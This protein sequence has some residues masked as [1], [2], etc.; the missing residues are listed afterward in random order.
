MLFSNLVQTNLRTKFLGQQIEYY[1]RLKST[2]EEGW[3]LS[4]D[5][6]KSG[7]V[8][9]TDNQFG[10]KGRNSRNWFTTP[11][12]SLSFSIL[13]EKEI[14]VKLC[15]WIPIITALSIERALSNFKIQIL[16][17]WPN[18]IILN[19]EK[20]GGVLIESKIKG[21]LV[22]KLIIGIGLNINE[23]KEE[24]DPTIK[25]LATSL[26]IYSGKNFQRER[27]LAEILNEMEPIIEGFPENIDMIRKSWTANCNHIDNKVQFHRGSNIISGIFKGLGENGSA[28]LKTNQSEKEFHSGEVY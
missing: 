13:I 21:K 24:L 27:I 20:I 28:I 2:N 10:G 25:S 6:A 23:S 9:I 7:T 26:H 3:E 18:D 15:G 5:G 8:V 22:N 17:K 1:T 14:P 4:N 11:N 12:K 16:L 19:G